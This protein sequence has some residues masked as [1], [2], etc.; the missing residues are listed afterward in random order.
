[1]SAICFKFCVSCFDFFFIGKQMTSIRQT[2]LRHIPQFWEVMLLLRL[3]IHLAHWLS[4][5]VDLDVMHY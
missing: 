3:L 5:W 2:R 1:M 4:S